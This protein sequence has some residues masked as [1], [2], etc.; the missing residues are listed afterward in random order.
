MKLAEALLL[1]A[2]R[3]RSL[4][5]AGRIHPSKVATRVKLVGKTWSEFRPIGGPIQK[6]SLMRLW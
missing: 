4:G 3:N 1:R 2:D 5:A 6:E